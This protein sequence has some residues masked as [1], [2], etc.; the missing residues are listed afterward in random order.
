M[1]HVGIILHCLCC[2]IWM[3]Q[4]NFR[5]SSSVSSSLQFHA[6]TIYGERWQQRWFWNSFNPL[7]QWNSQDSLL[8]TSWCYLFLPRPTNF[9]ISLGLLLPGIHY[10]SQP[11]QWNAPFHSLLLCF[12]F[13]TFF[14][15]Y[16]CLTP[17]INTPKFSSD[18][19]FISKFLTISFCFFQV[20]ECICTQIRNWRKVLANCAQFNNLFL[21]ANACYCD[22]NIWA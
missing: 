21:S 3:D 10:L 12:S 20:L 5:T 18:Q 14:L 17:L 8:R 1:F 7:P 11:G 22:R 15:K 13:S 6:K 9:T 2:D 19:H 16:S 4:Y